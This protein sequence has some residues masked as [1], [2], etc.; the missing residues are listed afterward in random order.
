MG[1]VRQPKPITEP[2][3][4]RKVIQKKPVRGVTQK[5]VSIQ[6]L[7][8]AGQTQILQR[9]KL[10]QDIASL[11]RSLS[12]SVVTA[13]TKNKNKNRKVATQKDLT[14]LLKRYNWR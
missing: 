9:N 11:A 6:G 2:T 10:I 1:G 13:A 5:D 14:A 7:P 4:R 8:R 3:R 12:S